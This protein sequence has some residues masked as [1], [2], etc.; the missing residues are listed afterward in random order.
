MTSHERWEGKERGMHQ[1][2]KKVSGDVRQQ[3]NDVLQKE[4]GAAEIQQHPCRAPNRLE[5][6]LIVKDAGTGILPR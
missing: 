3:V 4:H 2:R 1:E 6:K 5:V